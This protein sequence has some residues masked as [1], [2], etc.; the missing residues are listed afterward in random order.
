[1]KSEKSH[2]SLITMKENQ[3]RLGVT[4]PGPRSKI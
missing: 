1:M 2:V 3:L 4:R